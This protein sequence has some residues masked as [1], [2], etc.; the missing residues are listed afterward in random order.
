MAGQVSDTR[1]VA[2]QVR[3]SLDTVLFAGIERPQVDGI[4]AVRARAM[5]RNEKMEHG[6]VRVCADISADIC[7]FF[8]HRYHALLD[9]IREPH[10]KSG[11]S[12]S[13]S[14]E[15]HGERGSYLHRRGS[16]CLRF[17]SRRSFPCQE[18]S[19]VKREGGAVG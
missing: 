4:R 12:L 2:R 19:D 15:E 8:G 17:F 18:G 13:V 7:F 10:G 9:H 1:L 6:G 11:F 5:E 3:H 16:L 14:D